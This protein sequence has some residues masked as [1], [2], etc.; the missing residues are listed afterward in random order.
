MSTAHTESPQISTRPAQEADIS[1][2]AESLTPG[3]SA[4]QM[5]D[6]W[7][8][9]TSGIR[10]I[11]VAEI[12]G[13]LVGTISIGETRHYKTDSLRA[14]SL[15]VGVAYR[16]QGVGAALIAYAES[17][18]IR[19]KF[20]SIH[21]EVGTTNDD[22]VRLYEAQGYK[23]INKTVQNQWWVF[24]GDG[25]RNMEEETSWVMTKPLELPDA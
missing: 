23:H 25:S 8:E 24:Q 17:E 22:A 13:N 15:D 2:L 18:A 20:K 9:H 16:R 5:R 6:R 10:R 3:V 7:E 1:P 11:L 21:H 14:L 12:D 19:L 4:E